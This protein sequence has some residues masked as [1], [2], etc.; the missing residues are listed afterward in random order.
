MSHSLVPGPGGGEGRAQATGQCKGVEKGQ[1]GEEGGQRGRAGG[2]RS[3]P[4]LHTPW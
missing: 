2:S 3:V 1:R 4:G